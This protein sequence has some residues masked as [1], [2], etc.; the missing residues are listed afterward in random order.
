[1]DWKKLR[2]MLIIAKEIKNMANGLVIYKSKYGAT[3][4]YAEWLSEELEYDIFDLSNVEIK[5]VLKYQNILLCGG[6]YA[7]GINGLTFFKKHFEVLRNKNIA[8]FC[9]GASPYDEKLFEE[10]KMRNLKVEMQNIPIYYGRGAWDERKMKFFDRTLCNIL[11]KA[12]AKKDPANYEPWE[13][14]LVS[15]LGKTCDWTD[16][17]Y[18]QPLIEYMKNI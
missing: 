15:A 13:T 6:I 3:K 14:A 11:Q 2:N 1:M 18:L 17:K 5:Q 12:V 10:I 7:S 16:K 4:K 9:V 8:I